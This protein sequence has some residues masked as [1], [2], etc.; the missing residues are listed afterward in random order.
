MDKTN[1]LSAKDQSK[2]KKFNTL[3]L[4][5]HII[6]CLV[7]LYALACTLIII[8]NYYSINECKTGRSKG[9]YKS[10]CSTH[11]FCADKGTGHQISSKFSVKDFTSTNTNE[12]IT[13]PVPISESNVE[14]RTMD[15]IYDE[16]FPGPSFHGLNNIGCSPNTSVN[17][18]L[19]LTGQAV[20]ESDWDKAVVSQLVSKCVSELTDGGIFYSKHKNN[21]YLT[22]Q[23]PVGNLQGSGPC[24]NVSS[25]LDSGHL[26]E[27]KEIP[28]KTVLAS[29]NDGYR[30]ARYLLF[31]AQKQQTFLKQQKDAGKTANY[32]CADPS[33]IS[34]VCTAQDA[35]SG[36]IIKRTLNKNN[37]LYC[38]PEGSK[39]KGGIQQCVSWC[40]YS[41]DNVAGA[42]PFDLSRN[43]KTKTI[44]GQ[45]RSYQQ[46]LDVLP[47][48]KA[49]EP[50]P[51]IVYK[52]G[53]NTLDITGKFNDPYFQQNVFCGGQ[54][55]P[56][57]I[58]EG[59]TDGT[60]INIS[61][62]SDPWLS[63]QPNATLGNVGTGDNQKVILGFTQNFE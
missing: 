12:T 15:V 54:A 60:S 6:I 48:K 47:G 57:D 59:I 63:T 10:F 1:I 17:N 33:V 13:F 39:L 43:P 45:N 56:R 21:N 14:L 3:N 4:W 55:T 50:A 32:T 62:T 53:G 28:M 58:F 18:Q 51:E 40:S 25:S 34:P 19:F 9:R 26:F 7:A 2:I 49:L 30:D 38:F 16:P 24:F 31:E 42:N 36:K 22:Y 35:D 5:S 11:L 8:K 46:I 44:N 23:F 61:D 27:E 41:V 37:G 52:L 20:S 29:A